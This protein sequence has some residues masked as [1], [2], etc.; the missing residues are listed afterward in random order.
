MS[1][2]SII[3][4][5]YNPGKKLI[6]CISSIL[7]QTFKNFEL[8]LVNDGSTDESLDVCKSYQEKD[9]RVIIIDK[10]NEG[11]ILSRKR[12]IEASNS[13]YVMF[14]DA[15]DWIDKKLVETLLNE[16]KY[17]DADISV[18]N[19]YKVLG[20]SSLIKRK[21]NNIYFKDNRLF[22]NE[23][24][25]NELIEAYLWGHPFPSSLFAKLYKRELLLSSGNYLNRIHFLGDDLFYNLEML[26]K[27]EKVKVIDKP[28]YYYRLGGFTSKFMPYLFDDMVNGY[29]IQKEVI[30]EYFKGNVQKHY[31]GINIM[32]LNTFRTCLK[33][34]FN[35]GL[36]ENNIK[37]LLK[38]YCS[39]ESIREAIENEGCKRYFSRDFLISIECKDVNYL[40]E[41]GYSMYK[42]SKKR[43][44][45][46]NIAS[47]IAII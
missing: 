27:V 28:L 34:I 40:F 31:N 8:I 13:D 29:L 3:V 2:V 37:E 47:K 1:E 46:I 4:P 19:T 30:L 22:Q 9:N 42:K 33:N 32:L 5:I 39:N 43:K 38:D 12:G 26:L 10:K 16:L 6:K 15:D 17:N 44:L 21:N 36:D 18:C 20:N 45:F 25:K 14:V 35:S 24:I 23:S 11:S 7:K 41:L